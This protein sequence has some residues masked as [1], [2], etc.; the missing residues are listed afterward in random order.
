[1]YILFYCHDKYAFIRTWTPRLNL[2]VMGPSVFCVR[3]WWAAFSLQLLL[4]LSI[5]VSVPHS[6]GLALTHADTHTSKLYSCHPMN[7]HPSGS[8]KHRHHVQSL[9]RWPRRKSHTAPR[10]RPW[11]FGW[12]FW[13]PGG[14]EH[15]LQGEVQAVGWHV[16]LPSQRRCTVGGGPGQEGTGV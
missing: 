1:M 3:R 11:P 2:E 15:G 10:S 8:R 7:S 9:R 13:G 16:P 5:P 6:G 14:Q 4:S 12:G